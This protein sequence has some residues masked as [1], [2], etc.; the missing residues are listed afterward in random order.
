MTMTDDIVFAPATSMDSAIVPEQRWTLELIAIEKAPPSTFSDDNS[1]RAKWIFAL[2]DD[3]GERFYFNGEPYLFHRHTSL[4]NS[5]RAFARIYSEALLD[6]R[7]EDGDVPTKAELIG[8]RMSGQVIYEP[9]TIDP[10]QQVLKLVS[11]R[12]VTTAP[13]TAPALAVAQVAPSGD[14][15]RDLLISSIEKQI[16]KLAKLDSKKAKSWQAR[17]LDDLSNDEL[18]DI[19]AAIGAN[20]VDA[21]SA[22]D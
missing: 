21:L 18:S 22:E 5:P 2:Y 17:P 13:K 4:K 7:L 10:N 11:L 12:P 1:P 16:V 3:K 14:V 19:K 20:L 9:G 6:R 8:K 15:D